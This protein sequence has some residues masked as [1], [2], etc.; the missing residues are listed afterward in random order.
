MPDTETPSRAS[1]HWKNPLQYFFQG[2]AIIAPVGITIYAV[3]WL[4]T[5][6]VGCPG[7]GWNG[8][9]TLPGTSV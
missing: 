5:T 4:F 1:Y 8:E 6:V 2:L 9:I 3:L 7:F